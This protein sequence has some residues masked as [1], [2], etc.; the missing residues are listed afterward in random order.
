[1][2]GAAPAPDPD[3]ARQRE[4][5]DAFFA[6]ARDGNLAALVAVLAPD[7]VLRA[8]GGAARG[9]P[10]VVIHGAEAV[11]A[12]ASI[13]ARLAPFARPALINGTP[14]VV[15]AAGG[16]AFSVMG[17]TVVHGKIVAIDVLYDPARLANLDLT[18]LDDAP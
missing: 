14:G 17:F 9:R 16:R 15:V 2:R 5:V 6:A 18:I 4:V 12:Q 1:V 3:R 10:T 8:D 13:G 7:V 11:A